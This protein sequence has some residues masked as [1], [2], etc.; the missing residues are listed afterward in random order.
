MQTDLHSARAS[1]KGIVHIGVESS[2]KQSKAA[3]GGKKEGSAVESFNEK[4]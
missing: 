4:R 2:G 1:T 3:L